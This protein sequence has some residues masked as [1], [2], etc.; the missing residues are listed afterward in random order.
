MHCFPSHALQP[1]DSGADLTYQDCHSDYTNLDKV[2]KMDQDFPEINENYLSED[3]W[4]KF[5]ALNGERIIW[6]SWI[7]KYSDYINPAYLGDN[8]ELKLNEQ[9]IPK[10]HSTEPICNQ[11]DSNLKNE[12]DN[13]RERKFSYDSKV[14]PYKKKRKDITVEDNKMDRTIAVIVNKDDLW[15]PVNRRRSC[16]EHERIVSPRTLAGTDSM[17]NVTKL[18]LSS[19]NITSSHVTSV[20]T[21]TDDYSVSSRS[22]DDQF[23][24]QT[25]IV[26]I[27]YT[28]AQPEETDSEEHWQFLWK[29]HFGEQYA[30]HF[31]N[32]LECHEVHNKL[33]SKINVESKMEELKI[34]EIEC[35]NSEGN[36]QELPSVIEVQTQID[37]IKL[38]EKHVKTRKRSKKSSNRISSSVGMLLQTLLKEQKEKEADPVEQPNEIPADPPVEQPVDLPIDQ[39]VEH[40]IDQPVD[41][42][43]DGEDVKGSYTN[44]LPTLDTID[45]NKGINVQQFK[46]NPASYNYG[47]D[48]DDEPPEEKPVSLKRR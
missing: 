4:D 12:N 36:S 9:N 7:E 3:T 21:P 22:S 27:E 6:A 29:K 35:E 15:V 30:L 43:V 31:A 41:Y 34:S 18:T 19:H 47:D 39:P 20:S 28:E 45:S 26:N 37:Q 1:S 16:S 25:R 11:L 24:D 38:D 5:W 2:E 40:P 48:E 46:Y 17:T 14:N 10:Q 44:D 13:V 33:V 42:P 8:N 32:Y 23:N